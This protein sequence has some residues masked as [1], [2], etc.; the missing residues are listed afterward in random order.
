M[1]IPNTTTFNLRNVTTELN[2]GNGDGLWECFDEAVDGDFDLVYSGFKNNLLNFR[3]YGGVS[4]AYNDI[5]QT[6]ST[7]DVTAISPAIGVMV[8]P[9]GLKVYLND[10]PNK[11]IKQYSLS[12]ANDLA[13]AF[14]SVGS[15]DLSSV[16]GFP[17]LFILSSDGTKVLTQT[18]TIGYNAGIH[19]YSLSTA[20]DITSINLTEDGYIAFPS[21]T[22]RGMSYNIDGTK[23]YLLNLAAGGIYYNVIYWNLSTAYDITTAGSA[24]TENLQSIQ[25]LHLQTIASL[26]TSGVET[27]V[28]SGTNNPSGYTF[29]GG[30]AAGNIESTGNPITIYYGTSMSSGYIYSLERTNTLPYVWSIFQYNTHI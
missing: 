2:L 1:A 14:T 9:T 29:S 16:S 10:R 27:V 6:T 28:M 21:G 5:K 25:M 20:W 22:N 24:V 17:D 12:T 4:W 11:T 3:N 23:L 13:S 15:K 30:I 8:D 26:N 18:T 19:Q 7:I